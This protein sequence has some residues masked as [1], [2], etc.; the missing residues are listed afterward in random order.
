MRI[1][2]SG[3]AGLT[4]LRDSV[5]DEQHFIFIPGKLNLSKKNQRSLILKFSIFGTIGLYMFVMDIS[6]GLALVE[7]LRLEIVVFAHK[8]RRPHLFH[9]DSLFYTFGL[10]YFVL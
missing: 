4:L 10:V 2:V 5:K 6:V 9:R 8:W 7:N 1:W 3:K